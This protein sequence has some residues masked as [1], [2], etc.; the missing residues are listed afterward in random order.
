MQ[1]DENKVEEEDQ[2]FAN[3]LEWEKASRDTI[4]FKKI[5]VDITGNLIAGLMLSQIIYWYLPD[6]NGRTKLRVEKRD[7]FCL[8]KSRHEW[9]DEIRFNP[10]QVDKGLKIL[11]EKGIVKTEIHRFNGSPTIHIFLMKKILVGLLNK[12]LT[13]MSRMPKLENT[14]MEIRKYE[15]GNQKILRTLTETTPEIT[16]IDKKIKDNSEKKELSVD[17]SKNKNSTPPEEKRVVVIPQKILDGIVEV[18]NV[19]GFPKHKLPADGK[20]PTAIIKNV[21]NYLISIKTGRYCRDFKLSMEWVS[22]NKIDKGK[23]KGL[24]T[25]EELFPAL[26]KAA[27]GFKRMKTNSEY[28]P[29]EKKY[30]KRMGL[31][32]FLYNPLKENSWFLHCLSKRPQKL[33]TAID[34]KNV[35]ALKSKFSVEE[36]EVLNQLKGENWNAGIFWNKSIEMK[37]WYSSNIEMLRKVHSTSL[38]QGNVNGVMGTFKSFL[39]IYQEFSQ[40]WESWNLGNF[41]CENGTWRLFQKW[42]EKERGILLSPSKAKIETTERILSRN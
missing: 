8:V 42:I 12:E 25:W 21:Y 15:Y 33:R 11:R 17:P 18:I 31:D 34:D 22:E 7:V 41:G 37:N 2:E 36:Q 9:W 40:T 23:L 13:A 3:F 24:S 26:C 10:T 27:R 16:D 5:Y 35:S 32:T 30:L 39:G 29:A 14:N 38:V 1:E 19:G 20:P 28:W 6:K 4:D